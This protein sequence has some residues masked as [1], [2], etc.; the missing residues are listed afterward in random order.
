MAGGADGLLVVDKPKGLTSRQVVDRARRWFPRRTR[1]GHA[2]TL[3]PLATGV[4]VVA[5][6]AATRL[7][8]YVQRM[9]KV[10]Q[11]VALLGA[12]STTDDAEGKIT[13]T[14]A[15]PV[16]SAE[17]VAA[18]LPAFLG[19]I[20]QVPPAFS[21]AKVQGR[22]A[23]ELARRGRDVA[24]QARRVRVD[25]IALLAYEY[26]RLSLEIRCGK[27]TYVRS[28][29]R[30][31]GEQLGCGALV[32]SLRRIRIG[33]FCVQGAVSPDADPAT[34]R[35]ALQPLAAAVAELPRVDVTAEE[36]GRLGRGQSIPAAGRL[37]ETTAGS[38]VAVFDP[39]GRLV[40]VA[41]GD[42]Q[43]GRLRPSK[44]LMSGDEA[45]PEG[46]EE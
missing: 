24:L 25:A 1:L 6:G 3:D 29:V 33:P 20:E 2:G 34:A 46:A 42:P 4:L 30:D 43:S 10:Y 12:R 13:P 19:A 11:A 21:A 15:P 27:G 38:D 36:A 28:L 35:A 23:Y 14:P 8:E 17:A 32:E 41:V 39:A 9:G 40:G 44:I 22:R 16:P 26:P 7:I 31:L 18:C 37:A 45:R 5:A